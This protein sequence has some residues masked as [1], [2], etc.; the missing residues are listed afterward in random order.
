MRRL[1]DTLR[2]VLVFSILFAPPR[3]SFAESGGSYHGSIVINARPET[4]WN[5][6]RSPQCAF[7]RRRII[8]HSQNRAVLEETYEGL[9]VIHQCTCMF[10]E[11]ETPYKKIEYSL[12]KSDHIKDSH[13]T[14]TLLPTNDGRTVLDLN[15]YVDTGIN[16]PL[17][18]QITSHVVSK[19]VRTR[20]AL[21]KGVA[22]AQAERVAET[23]VPDGKI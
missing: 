3:P 18:H 1:L 16:I 6:L 4:V 14:W 17:A 22:E 7:D 2:A 13:G 12:L 8:S 10:E 19:R 20:L 5:A 21:V 15:S 11:R 23:S 9:P